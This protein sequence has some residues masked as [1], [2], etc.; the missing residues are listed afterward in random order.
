VRSRV[1]LRA[2]GHCDYPEDIAEHA[3]LKI[4]SLSCVFPNS[5]DPTLGLFVRSR[6]Q[7]VAA[8][9]VVKVISPVPMI[10]YWRA[11]YTHGAW[12][13]EIAQHRQDGNL[14][15]FHPSWFYLPFGG[16]LNAAFLAA[17]LLL[18]VV[19][20]RRRFSF[21]LIDAHFAY[22]DGIAAGI[23]AQL[24]RV[25]FIVSLRGNETMHAGHPF[26]AIFIRWVL[27]RANR[28]ICLS[29]SLRQFANSLGVDP[30]RTKTIPNGIDTK[31][32][33][34]RDR[35]AS[36]QKYMIDDDTTVIL[37]VGALIERKGHHRII[38]AL[39]ELQEEGVDAQLL[40][41]GSAGREGHYEQQL[42]KLVSELRM[43]SKVRFLGQVKPEFLPELMSAADV[44][45]LPTTR[46][47]W[48]NVVHEAMG[49]GTPV[50]ATNVGGIPDMIPSER[51]GIV[52][53]VN[54]SAALR[55]ALH[56]AFGKHWDRQ[57]IAGWA[58]SRSWEQVARESL[59]QMQAVIS[60]V[61][62]GRVHGT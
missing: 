34:P 54:D 53:P 46:E 35:A 8:G 5:A 50:V 11:T 56:T 57:G 20:L 14:E 31:L 58:R 29:E 49:C 10:D 1:P 42:H 12:H 27:R 25:P 32:F 61:A 43:E 21:D 41:A 2:A 62:N 39:K 59:E 15:V 47:G 7:S 6:L 19:R 55:N 13:R 26:R 45:C 30:A 28:V 51:Y 4:L 24:L 17:R 22:P 60:E 16:V 48:P 9:A 36:R 40:I 33:Y 23:L 18:P 44:F 38:H 52:V 37:S 3:R